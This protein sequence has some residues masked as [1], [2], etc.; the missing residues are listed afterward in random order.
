MPDARAHRA[1]PGA[2]AL[3]VLLAEAEFLGDA[4]DAERL[5]GKA[6]AKDVVRRDGVVG[7]GVN[8]AVRLFPKIR[9]VGDL[10][11]FVPVGG[12][13]TFATRALEGDAEAA[14]AAEEVNE[15]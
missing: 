8:V 2:G 6:G 9:L 11:L 4:R 5:A 7:N 14:N 15:A 1:A 12:E 10:R 3:P 13:D